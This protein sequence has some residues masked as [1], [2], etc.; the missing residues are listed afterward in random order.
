M[1]LR[2][3][4]MKRLTSLMAIMRDHI[5]IGDMITT[6]EKLAFVSLCHHFKTTGST[7]PAFSDYL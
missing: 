4:H 2:L 1:V 5:P 7:L 3:L 6:V